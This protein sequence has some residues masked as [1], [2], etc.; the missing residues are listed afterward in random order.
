MFGCLIPLLCNTIKYLEVKDL[1]L[2][3]IVIIGLECFMMEFAFE[4]G[5]G[6][7]GVQMLVRDN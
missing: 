6:W 5:C 3:L 7:S 4:W 2:T 1:T